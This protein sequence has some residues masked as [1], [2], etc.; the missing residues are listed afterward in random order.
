MDHPGSV[1][2]IV[3]R[4][5]TLLPQHR[6]PLRRDKPVR[7]SIPDQTPRYIFPSVERSFIFIPRA[8][9]PNQQPMLRGRGR[10]SFQGSRRPSIFGGSVYTPSVAMSRKSSFGPASRE[11]SPSSTFG[12]NAFLP[13]NLHKPIVRLPAAPPIPTQQGNGIHLPLGP[14]PY[15]Q[16]VRETHV[17]AIPIHQPRPK[18]TVSVADIDVPMSL[19]LRP[20]QQEQEQPFHQ[21]VPQFFTQPLSE[22]PAMLYS[23]SRRQSHAGMAT[24]TPLSQIPERAI[25]AQPFQPYPVFPQQAYYPMPYPAGPN[26]YHMPAGQSGS[27]PGSVP[28]GVLAPP[29]VPGHPSPAN[30]HQAPP[31]GQDGSAQPHS[32]PHESNG[33][34]YYYNPTQYPPMANGAMSGFAMGPGGM[35]PPMQ[36]FYPPSNGMFFPPQ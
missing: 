16:N 11:R 21:Q 3:K 33:M 15:P 14:P 28:T 7:I 13:S 19:E 12:S 5:H 35:T 6:P 24:G 10:G 4:H 23:R 17:Q 32:V 34:V 20:P 29:F 27:Y 9:R 36:F 22:D 8:L 1:P 25:Y 18:K 30:V 31:Q 26:F 2:N